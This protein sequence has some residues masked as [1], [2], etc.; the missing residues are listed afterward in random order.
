MLNDVR[1]QD[2]SPDAVGFLPS[3]RPRFHEVYRALFEYTY[4]S[5][6]D[7]FPKKEV[8][9]RGV[10]PYTCIFCG[11]SEPEVSFRS[12]SHII[13]ASFG[14]R[15]LFSSGECDGC[16]GLFGRCFEDELANMFAPQRAFFRIRK[17]RGVSKYKRSHN[18]NA[19]IQ[20]S[21]FGDFLEI[22]L[23]ENDGSIRVVHREDNQLSLVFDPIAF[24]PTAAL[25]SLTHSLWFVLDK[26]SNHSPSELLSWMNGDID[27]FPNIYHVVSLPGPGLKDIGFYVW[28]LE[29]DK[30]HWILPE[31][32]V[33]LA[34]GCDIIMWGTPDFPNNQHHERILLPSVPFSPYWPFV[35]DAKKFTILNDDEKVRPEEFRMDL[36]FGRMHKIL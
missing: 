27:I 26:Y 22:S 5:L 13:P 11:K 19:Y 7:E 16:N 14:N 29:P 28:Q 6:E 3:L 34:F 35:P 8:W 32:V 25:K 31:F 15:T 23:V 21:S 12:D 9:G 33:A 10:R 24:N 2:V 17:R 1:N 30:S 20:G 18:H 36:C 4:P